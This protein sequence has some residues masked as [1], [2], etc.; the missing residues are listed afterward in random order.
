MEATR[1]NLSIA[2]VTESEVFPVKELGEFW[3][4]LINENVDNVVE[5]V[6]K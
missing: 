3:I 5:F 2:D 6:K 4:R 1:T